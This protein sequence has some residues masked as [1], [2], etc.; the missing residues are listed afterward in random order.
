YDWYAYLP[1]AFLHPTALQIQGTALLLL[2]LLWVAVRFVVKQ[3]HERGGQDVANVRT[4]SGSER[5]V[6]ETKSG[7]DVRAPG[8]W[9]SAARELLD[10][11]FAFDRLVSWVVLGGFVLLS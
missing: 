1:H 10:T 11:R 9:S 8:E 5:V 2:S 7:Q 3:Q 4:A 6:D